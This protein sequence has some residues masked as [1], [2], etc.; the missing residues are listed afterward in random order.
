LARREQ[1]LLPDGSSRALKEVVDHV[2]MVRFFESIR[3]D[4]LEFK[5]FGWMAPSEV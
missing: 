1:A 3:S 5:P 2:E 4:F